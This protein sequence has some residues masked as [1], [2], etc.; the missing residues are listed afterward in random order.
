MNHHPDNESLLDD[1]LSGAAPGDFR[2]AVLE[3]TLRLARRR[4]QIRQGRRS[5]LLLAAGVLLAG[6]VWQRLARA[7]ASPPSVTRQNPA[8][9]YHLVRT[10]PLPATAIVTTRPFQADAALASSAGATEV[11]TTRG[12]YRVINDAELL[13]LVAGPAVLVRT[14]PHSEELVFADPEDRKRLN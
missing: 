10:E 3:Q 4:R 9:A 6:L 2:G 7:P 5:A 12:G 14:G 11:T 8:P 13:E 1:V